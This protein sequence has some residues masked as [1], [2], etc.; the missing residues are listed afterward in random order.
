MPSA[1]QE[2]LDMQNETQAQNR[3]LENR[4]LSLEMVKAGWGPGFFGIAL[5]CSFI[6]CCYFLLTVP[7]RQSV[8]GSGEII[9]FSPMQRPQTIEAQIS[10]R[11]LRWLV[12]D[13]EEVSAG[14]L[15]AEIS[16]IDP[17]YLSG[18]KQIHSLEEQKAALVAKRESAEQKVESL[19][20]QLKDQSDSRGAALPAAEERIGQAKLRLFAAQQSVDVAEQNVKTTQW[21]LDRINT[22]FE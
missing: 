16:D 4:L 5:L 17:R 6:F 7:W 10:G 13:G 14:Q 8:A 15:L 22:L 11:L 1:N 12:K 21:Q 20:N 9:V 18:E 2:S 19:S 3:E